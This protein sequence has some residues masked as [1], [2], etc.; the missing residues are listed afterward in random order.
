M[1]YPNKQPAGNVP[2]LISAKGR[3][4]NVMI[5][6]KRFDR[7]PNVRDN[8]DEHGEAEFVVDACSNC[9]AITVQVHRT[10]WRF[11]FSQKFWKF[12]LLLLLLLPLLLPLLI[13]LTFVHLKRGKA[14]AYQHITGDYE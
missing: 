11:L 2:M 4:G 6:L 13:T 8:T 1:T 7:D 14:T 12:G 10:S 5:D 9:K 3:Q